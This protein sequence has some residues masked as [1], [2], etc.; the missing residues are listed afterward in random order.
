M[1]GTVVVVV[2]LPLSALC[3]RRA[4]R[5][6]RRA[7]FRPAA[8]CHRHAARRRLLPCCLLPSPCRPLLSLCCP[9][10]ALCCMSPCF[11]Q[12]SL[13][14]SRIVIDVVVV[15]AIDADVSSAPLLVDCCMCP[16]PSLCRCRWVCGGV[17]IEVVA[18]VFWW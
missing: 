6:R 5:H 8:P 18:D 11:L 12:M 10:L 4:A 13:L 2:L 15:V 14:P 1:V 3:R 17:R 16:P 9:S 7:V